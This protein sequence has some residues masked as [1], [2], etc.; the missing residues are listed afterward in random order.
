MQFV[1]DLMPF[2]EAKLRPNLKMAAHRIQLVNSK[3]ENAI[4][5]QKREV[6]SIELNE[7]ASLTWS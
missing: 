1:K 4:K 2:S 6:R 7:N 3:K 5:H